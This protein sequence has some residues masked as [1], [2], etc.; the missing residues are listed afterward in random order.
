MTQLINLFKTL[1]TIDSPSGEEK[2]ISQYVFSYL[3]KLGFQ[4]KIDKNQQ[5]YCH[6]NNNPAKPPV[7]FCAHLDTVEP[8][9]KIKVIEKDGYLC[10]DEKTILGADNKAAVAAI[11]MAIKELKQEK[12]NVELIFSVKEE[13]DGGIKQFNYK[14]IKS[15]IGFVFDYA[16]EDLGKIILKAP[17]IYDFTFQFFGRSSHASR[18][19]K[20]IN[21]LNHFLKTFNYLKIGRVDKQ[22]AFNLGL[23]KGGQATNSIPDFL[24]IKGDVRSL[25]K[26]SF[27][28]LIKK[29]EK[30]FFKNDKKTQVKTKIIWQPYCHGYQIKENDLH[31]QRLRRFYQKNFAIN[32][33]PIFST[34]GSDASFLNQI[35]VKTFCL[36][37]GSINSHTTK[38]RIKIDKLNMLKN[39]IKKILLYF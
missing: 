12:I 2:I 6:I 23:I 37:D 11:L 3:K 25:N 5:I 4:P 22:T 31:Y 16:D 29:V 20:G 27:F 33:K 38:E 32:L 36:A 15:K 34:G 19:E 18:P 21:V 13:T 24:E 28:S 39:I 17:Y 26:K 35:G 8:G 1:V 14:K 30:T 7:L 10:S 9:R